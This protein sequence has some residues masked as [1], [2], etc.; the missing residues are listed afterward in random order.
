[1]PH[2]CFGSLVT[3]QYFQGK[4]RIPS[5]DWQAW[6]LAAAG[7]QQVPLCFSFLFAPEPAACLDLGMQHS[8]SSYKPCP[9]ECCSPDSFSSK[10]F[11]ILQGP[12]Y[13]EEFQS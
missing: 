11:S 12:A 1:M 10:F 5:F 8:G 9:L 7:A 3:S 4:I 2:P 13:T 6:P